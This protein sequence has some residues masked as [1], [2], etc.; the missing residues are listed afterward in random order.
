[1]TRY[2]AQL[3]KRG[4]DG[5]IERIGFDPGAYDAGT[6]N[7]FFTA[8]LMANGGKYASDDGRKLLFDGPQ[9]S[10]ALDWTLQVLRGNGGKDAVAEFF[11]RARK[12]THQALI[13]G[14][15]AM[16]VTNHSLP[17]NAVLVPE[18]QYGIGLLPR[19]SQNG[20]RGIVRGGWSN[21]IPKGVPAAHEFVAA[22]AVPLRF[23]GRAGA[24]SWSSRCA[25]PRSRR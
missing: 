11:G 5:R 4:G 23:A 21:A 18:L 20:A 12:N 7:S 19:G 15:R 14:E 16:Y 17:S 2:A 8:W 10:G 9:A 1:M 25:P 24:G 13:S 22:A 3:L 6:F